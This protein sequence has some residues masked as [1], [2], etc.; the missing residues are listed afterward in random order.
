MKHPPHEDLAHIQELLSSSA[1]DVVNQA[2]ELLRIGRTRVLLGCCDV[3]V[4]VLHTGYWW[5]LWRCLFAPSCR[6][7]DRGRP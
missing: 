2:I 3:L 4:A 1:L 7:V 5:C 6:A